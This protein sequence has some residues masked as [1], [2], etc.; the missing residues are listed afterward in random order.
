MTGLV[1]GARAARRRPD[2]RAPLRRDDDG[3]PTAGVWRAAQWA[4]AAPPRPLR[5]RD[6]A[7]ARF[8][9]RR[10]ARTSRVPA[11]SPA[12]CPPDPL[13]GLLPHC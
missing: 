10:P 11:S 12:G 8:R 3:V 6:A 13:A 9:H 2:H 1:R 4:A 5:R 7:A